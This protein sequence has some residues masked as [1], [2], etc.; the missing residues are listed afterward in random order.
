MY[1]VAALLGGSALSV[2]GAPQRNDWR[3]DVR[4]H[5]PERIR[6]RLPGD[7]SET[8]Y[9]Y[10]IYEVINNTGRDRHF[11]SSFRL[12][13]DTL[14]VVRGGDAIS[15]SVY[16]AIMARHRKEIPFLTEPNK[17][18]GMLLQGQANSRTTMVAFRDFDVQANSFTIFASG[19]SG[20]VERMPN[21]IFRSDRPESPENIRAFMK[22]ETLEI[23]YDLPGDPETRARSAP[24][25]RS[26]AW[27]MR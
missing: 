6:L 24:L 10:V 21:P 5:D 8:T 2:W 14:A 12:V 11:F 16:D 25:R 9:W 23:R 22:R 26:K 15:P 1:I 3:F 17:A 19:F 13:P 4:I 7:K 27:V 20:L 18:F